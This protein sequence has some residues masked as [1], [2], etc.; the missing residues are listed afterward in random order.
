MSFVCYYQIPR[1]LVF[2]GEMYLE[3]FYE[4]TFISMLVK[5][6]IILFFIFVDDQMQKNKFGS[7]L[8]MSQNG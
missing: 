6:E 4:Q 7:G 3:P 1:R 8:K 5:Q 2:P